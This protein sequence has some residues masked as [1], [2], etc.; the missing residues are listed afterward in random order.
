MEEE[1]PAEIMQRIAMENNLAETAFL[2]KTDNGYNLR[3]FTPTVEIKLCGHATVA[4]AHILWEKGILQKTEMARFYTKSGLLTVIKVGEWIQLNF[5]R[6]N[7]FKADV[8]KDLISALNIS[9]INSF[10]SE[11]SR[12]IIEV[13]NEQEVFSLNPDFSILKNYETVV[14]TSQAGH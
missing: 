14:I 2:S 5:P 13:E 7:Y 3:W 4:S 8:P 6:F 11:D 10:Q 12:Y 1:F 9:P